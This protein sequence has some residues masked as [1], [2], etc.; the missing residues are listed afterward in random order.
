M[1]TRPDSSH[2]ASA[3]G[4]SRWGEALASAEGKI[5]LAG[6]LLAVTYVAGLVLTLN[7]SAGLFH[8]LLGIT[9]THLI[10]GRAAGLTI[11]YSY[12]LPRW[13]VIGVNMAIETI[14]VLIIYPV[15]VL[16]YRKLIAIGPLKDLLD[17]AQHA[18][19]SQQRRIARYGVPMLFLFVWFPMYFTGPVVGAIIGYLIGLRPLVNLGVVLTGTYAAVLCWGMALHRLNAALA[20]LGPYPPLIFVELVLLVV[21]ALLVRRVLGEHERHGRPPEPPAGQ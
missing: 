9:S 2:T 5:L 11:G 12:G 14:V 13:V 15:F 17:Q 7:W 1:S 6:L 18:A 20:S 3:R 4:R 19:E 21:V 16:S 10:G 8:K